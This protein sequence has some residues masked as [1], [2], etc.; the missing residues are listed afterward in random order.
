VPGEAL[1]DYAINQGSVTAGSNYTINYICA[2]FSI[3]ALATASPRDESSIGAL[4]YVRKTSANRLTV[5]STQKQYYNTPTLLAGCV[6]THQ[7]AAFGNNISFIY[8]FGVRL[9]SNIQSICL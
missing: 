6:P 8:N 7:T 2:D 1:G 5:L 3:T 4:A 9:P